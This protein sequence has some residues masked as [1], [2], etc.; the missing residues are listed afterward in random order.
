MI[1]R[2]LANF[3]QMPFGFFFSSLMPAISH[4]ESIK[5]MDRVRYF[6]LKITKPLSFMIFFVIFASC[7]AIK[8]IIFAWMGKP[9]P[10]TTNLFY[11]LAVSFGINIAL[12]GLGTTIMRGVAR[13][14][15]EVR[16][17]LFRHFTTIIFSFIG[18]KYIGFNG[19]IA[20]LFI[21]PIITAPYFSVKF[22][23]FLNLNIYEFY[24]MVFPPFIAGLIIFFSILPFQNYLYFLLTSR[25]ERLLLAFLLIAIF[26][27]FYILSQI[28]FRVI[29]FKDFKNN[30]TSLLRQ[31]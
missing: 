21:I 25:I 10:E 19:V 31:N 4:L 13:P 15:Y 26:A 18:A 14:G 22:S 23:K 7:I 3:L 24:S 29:N 8:P 11:F 5:K 30:I 20:V 6:Y 2:R 1:A 27:I 16:L 28:L 9:L 12:T 17:R